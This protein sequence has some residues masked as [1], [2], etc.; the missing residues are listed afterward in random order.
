M[1]N[2]VD[3]QRVEEIIDYK[4]TRKALL[5]QALTAAHRVD[6]RDGTYESFHNN[7]RL[8]ALGEAAIKL[9][10]TE[11]WLHTDQPLSRSFLPLYQK[12]SNAIRRVTR[13]AGS[14]GFEIR[15][16]WNCYADR[17]K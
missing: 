3:L 4:F 9:I 1:A 6:F 13:R 12:T 10:L 11:D 2:E 17:H 8:G 15:T 16:R 7:K 14:A 5:V